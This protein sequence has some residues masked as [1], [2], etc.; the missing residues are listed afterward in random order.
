MAQRARKRPSS[1]EA[2]TEN[3]RIAAEVRILNCLPSAGTETDWRFENALEAGLLTAAPIPKSKD[4]RE[5][6]WKIGNQLNTGSCVGWAT[7]DSVLRWHLVKAKRIK[8]DD[9]LSVR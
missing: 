2:A 5:A 9:V 1:R 8:Q 3:P 4:L 7:A 6:W